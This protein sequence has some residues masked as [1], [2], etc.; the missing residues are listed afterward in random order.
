MRE[1]EFKVIQEDNG[2]TIV[3]L[4]Q[5]NFR[6]PEVIGHL[7]I[8]AMELAARDLMLRKENSVELDRCEFYPSDGPVCDCGS[9]V[10]GDFVCSKSYS[11]I[12][13]W[14]NKEREKES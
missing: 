8:A 4:A 9:D 13:P 10:S 14:A 3:S 5:D 6:I 12:C 7:I 2:H 11:L 1:I